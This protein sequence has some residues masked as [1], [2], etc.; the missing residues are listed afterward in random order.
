MRVHFLRPIDFSKVSTPGRLP[1]PSIS[2]PILEEP[3]QADTEVWHPYLLITLY[4][5][6]GTD[7]ILYFDF[8][9]HLHRKEI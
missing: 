7:V 2:L 1:G 8:K 3:G 9:G 6:D 5:N 4:L